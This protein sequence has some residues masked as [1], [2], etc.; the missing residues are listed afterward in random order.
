MLLHIKRFLSNV[1]E[2]LAH[3]LMDCHKTEICTTELTDTL[4]PSGIYQV[5]LVPVEDHKA[6][7]A[8]VASDYER[9][10]TNPYVL[11][12]FEFGLP[13]VKGAVILNRMDYDQLYQAV[14]K[15]HDHG[16]RI[17]LFITDHMMNRNV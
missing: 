9:S 10:E 5:A 2:T 4:L 1:N 14:S 15:C 12:S 13:V 3:L 16:E 7:I 11:A 8:I 6:A 17:D